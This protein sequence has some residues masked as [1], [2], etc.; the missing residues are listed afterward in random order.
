M[1]FDRNDDQGKLCGRIVPDRIFTGSDRFHVAGILSY[2][3]L[4]E[5]EDQNKVI[6]PLYAADLIGGCAGSV[7]AGLILMPLAGLDVT[8]WGMLILSVYSVLL[9]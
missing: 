7:L 1:R 5:I 4:H 6:S 9:L 8:L 3:S 2:A